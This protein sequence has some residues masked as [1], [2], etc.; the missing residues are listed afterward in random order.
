MGTLVCG[1]AAATLPHPPSLAHLER[2]AGKQGWRG[3][4]EQAMESTSPVL[5]SKTS[6]TI[7][8]PAP[9]K[10]FPFVG[11]CQNVRCATGHLHHLVAQQ[12]LHNLGLAGEE[13]QPSAETSQPARLLPSL[14]PGPPASTQALAASQ[15]SSNTSTREFGFGFFF[16]F[17]T[18]FK[19]FRD[20]VHT[21][22]MIAQTSLGRKKAA[23][24]TVWRGNQP[25]GWDS[26]PCSRGECQGLLTHTLSRQGLGARCVG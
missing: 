19:G 24:T 18:V 4:W 17:Q 1:E 16:L 10:H 2:T 13:Q 11:N 14:P 21:A 25:K 20:Y 9:G 5:Q 6:L 26:P 7:I 3:E 23:R 12:G 22:Q 15:F 8:P